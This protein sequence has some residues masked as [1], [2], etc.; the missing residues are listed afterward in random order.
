[1]LRK[2]RFLSADMS[3]ERAMTPIAV[4]YTGV[5]GAFIGIQQSIK[6]R[7]CPCCDAEFS[8]AST[9]RASCRRAVLVCSRR[10]S[11][12]GKYLAARHARSLHAEAG[13]PAGASAV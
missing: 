6:P 2:S 13:G 1:M 10:L 11:Q 5:A 12:G 7:W 8:L 4:P 3:G 9:K